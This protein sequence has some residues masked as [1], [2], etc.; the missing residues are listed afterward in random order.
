[1]R[2]KAR[3]LSLSAL[4]AVRP[5]PTPVVSFASNSFHSLH[6]NAAQT[7][8]CRRTHVPESY[9]NSVLS[10]FRTHIRIAQF[11]I[12]SCH[13]S[14]KLHRNTVSK[15]SQSP[16]ETYQATDWYLKVS[17]LW[18]LI[19]VISSVA[20]IPIKETHSLFSSSGKCQQVLRTCTLF[21]LNR[22]LTARGILV[23]SANVITDRLVL[24]L[25]HGRLVV[26]GSLAHAVLLEG[27][28]ACILS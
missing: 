25:L 26:L 4:R 3:V 9:G 11:V 8:P 16:I 17:I 1:M 24:G 7:L 23:L 22:H 15:R 10:A 6:D 19:H 18:V 28:D 13:F 21:I 2:R 14:N 5:S 12:L 20:R 27:V